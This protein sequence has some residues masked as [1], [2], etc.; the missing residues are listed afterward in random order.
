[1]TDRSPNPQPV[2]GTADPA[3]DEREALLIQHLDEFA[4]QS[5]AGKTPDFEAVRKNHPELFDELRQLW[6]TAMVAE[7]LATLS[8]VLDGPAEKVDVPR[9]SSRRL[10]GI[11]GSAITRFSRR[12]AAAEWASSIGRGKSAWGGSSHSRWCCA[13][14]WRRPPIARDFAAEAE[15]AARLHHPHIT[16]V[17]EVG[18]EDGQPYFSMQFVEGTT[19]A[20][21]IADGPLPAHEAARTLL[22]V[23]RAIAEA[24][25]G[26][27]LHRDLKPS[28]ILIDQ[29]GRPYVS[30]FGLAKRVTTAGETVDEPAPLF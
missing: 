28:N 19:L 23:C 17:Y 5:R 12:S 30:D 9:R 14:R 13:A 29:T 1:M 3:I 4:A 7:D 22:P 25:R 24:H 16:P 15:S 2:D 11:G 27:L 20:R 6:A 10:P 18:D 26:G 8:A 21:R